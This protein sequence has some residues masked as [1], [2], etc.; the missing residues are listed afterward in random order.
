MKKNRKRKKFI[1][2]VHDKCPYCAS[3]KYPDYKDYG[4]L[5]NYITDRARILS[6]S[7][8]GLCAKHQRRLSIEIKRARHLAL[9]PYVGSI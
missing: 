8:S 2:P 1:K 4:E 3:G 6:A 9:L 7:R 5:S